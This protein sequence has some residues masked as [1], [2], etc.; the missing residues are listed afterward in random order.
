[1]AGLNTLA[2][3]NEL[4][5]HAGALGIFDRVNT[6]EP[7]AVPG[8]GITCGIWMGPIRPATQRSGLDATT[9]RVEWLCRLYT[10][11]LSDPQDAIDPQMM[12]ATDALF[13]RLAGD[14]TLGNTVSNIDLLGHSGDPLRADPGYIN[15]D[16]KLLRVVTVYVPVIINDVW[17]QEE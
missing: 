2:V 4:E 9:A 17:D 13:T 6:H 1:M 5:S 11:M 8:S 15:Q 12:M 7:K 3:L 14:F 16:G 10:S